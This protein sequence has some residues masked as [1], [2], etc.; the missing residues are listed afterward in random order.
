M[1]LGG[2]VGLQVEVIERNRSRGWGSN[3]LL[4]VSRGSESR[5]S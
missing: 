3:T 2:K 4:S 1:I 5:P